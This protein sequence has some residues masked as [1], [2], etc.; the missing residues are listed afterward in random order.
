[1]GARGGVSMRVRGWNLLGGRPRTGPWVRAAGGVVTRIYGGS[2]SRTGVAAARLSE[3]G[4]SVGNCAGFLAL[5][6]FFGLHQ[7]RRL[8]VIFVGGSRYS[9]EAR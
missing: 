3:A 4:A 8:L 5:W 2:C 9:V 7:E 6:L 1:M